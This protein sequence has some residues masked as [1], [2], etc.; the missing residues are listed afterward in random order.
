VSEKLVMLKKARVGNNRL[1]DDLKPE[2]RPAGDRKIISPEV[3][4]ISIPAEL[5]LTEQQE[6]EIRSILEVEKSTVRLLIGQLEKNCQQLRI[7]AGTRLF[8]KELLQPLFSQRTQI[9]TE[10][11]YARERLKNRIYNVL[12]ADQRDVLEG[13]RNS[14]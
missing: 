10:L 12:R 1:R 4:A 6:A 3:M 5:S 14:R 11:I 8:D 2:R 9:E 7:A 13:Q